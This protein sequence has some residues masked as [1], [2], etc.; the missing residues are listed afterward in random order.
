MIISTN[1]PYFA[2]YPG[3]FYKAHLADYFVI[4]DDVQ[5]PRKTTWITR[6]RFKNDQGTLWMTIPV[7]K[8]GLGL[9]K[10]SEVRICHAGNWKKKYLRSIQSA[11]SNAPFFRDHMGLMERVLSLQYDD[12][13]GLN[14]D[15][16]NYVLDYL[17][18]ETRIV[19]MSE[20]GVS[21]KGTP[22]IIDICKSLG[23]TQFLVQSSALAYYDPAV[24][25]SEGIQLVSFK[26]PDY[27][28]PQMWGNF[29]ANLSVLD[30]M[31]TCGA[32]VRYIIL[33]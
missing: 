5:F 27:I 24:F 17:K 33:V 23:T 28:Y 12:L 22:L 9:Q 11:Y 21:G 25:D 3:F 2:P 16:I 32:K 14:L 26:K 13:L 19:L 30:M 31:F 1:Q 7:L 18:I 8:K 6:N 15:I 29:I 4:L 20:L 10:I